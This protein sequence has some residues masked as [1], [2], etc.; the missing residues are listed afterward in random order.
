M[1]DRPPELLCPAGSREAALAALCNGAD[2]LYLGAVSFG[3]RAGAGFDRQHLKEIIDLCH[4]YGRRVHVTV[5]TLVKQ[6]ELAGV[7]DTL[8]MLRDLRAD[9]VLVQDMGVLALIREQFPELT[10]HASTQMAIHSAAGARLL[11][12]LGVSRVVL[13]RECT[14]SD[15]RAVAGTGIETE[16]FVHGAQCVCVSGQ[17]RFSGLIGGRSGNRGRCAQPCRLPYTWEG[18]TANWLSPRDNC[19]FDHL[20][21]L[22]DAGVASLKI[23][24]RL[25]R[26]EYVAVVT[27][28]YRRALDAMGAAD[29]AGRD[30]LTRVFNRGFFPGYAFGA[31]DAAVINPGRVS[32]AG[33]IIGSIA[34]VWKKNGV[35]LAEASLTDALHNGDGLQIRGA[36]DQDIVYSGDA[37]PAGQKAV[38]RLHRPARSGDAVARIDDEALL[39]AARESYNKKDALPR[40]P[41]DAELTVSSGHPASLRVWDDRAEAVVAGETV[42]DAQ[43]VALNEDRARRALE[44]TGDTCFSLRRLT[45]SG[46]NAYLPAAALNDLRRRALDMLYQARAEAWALPRPIWPELAEPQSHPAKPKLYVQFTDPALALPF[47]ESGAEELIFAPL[48][49]TGPVLSR[50]LDEL[51]R[52]AWVALPVQLTGA[53]LT[54]V[55]QAAAARGMRLCAGSVGQAASGRML[56]EGVPCWNGRAARLLRSLGGILQVLPRELSRA[57]TDALLAAAPEGAYILPV[58]GRARLMYLN[59]C[60]ARTALG[61]QGDR[62]GCGLC[63]EGRGCQERSLTDRRGE[64]FPLLP[65]RLDAGC[66]VQLLS[67][68]T[69]SLNGAARRD[70]SWLLDFT[71]ETPRE[72]VAVVRAY[73]R[74]MDGGEAFIPGV[75]ERFD[76]GV[77]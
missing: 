25:K 19:L 36:Y 66:L 76:T 68:Q 20:Q 47:R 15:I 72:A 11:K 39:S 46:E 42:Q 50:A 40:I 73:R 10:V 9:A 55:A 65:L 44:K 6:K 61:L 58:Y 33:V 2:A 77:E 28:Q 59:H 63:G 31:R 5:N 34:G 17:C 41:F 18:K 4:V 57:E 75:M 51:P 13:A 62:S 22:M 56:G 74:M 45:V 12:K 16:V 26:P 1:T 29:N 8:S 30:A 23:E 48:D 7:F 32:S 35:Y 71:V 49:L 64:A 37:V 52:D 60:P 21:A 38:L 3:A 54:R 14:L 53:E 24:G 43:S 69:R 27:R 67:C 70:V